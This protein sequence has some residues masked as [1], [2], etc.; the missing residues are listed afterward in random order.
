[1]YA[2]AHARI[3]GKDCSPHLQVEV[4]VATILFLKGTLT[5]DAAKSEVSLVRT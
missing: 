2:P 1:M 3:K 4:P 5:L